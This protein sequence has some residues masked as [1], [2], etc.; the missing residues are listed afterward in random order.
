MKKIFLICPVRRILESERALIKKYIARL[1]DA[2]DAVYWPLRDTNQN[3][4]VGLRICEDN[5]RAMVRA[6]E[7]H[8]WWI[9]SSQGSLFDCGMAFAMGKKFVLA[10][11]NR[12]A[13][14]AT[15]KSF[16]NVLIAL[17]ADRD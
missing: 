3:D 11:R 14:T 6:D 12:V 2:G 10:N 16:E 13:W 1:E 9:S 8:V 17:D 4:P 7:I 5:L 15:T